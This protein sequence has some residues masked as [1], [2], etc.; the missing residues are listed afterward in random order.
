[1]LASKLHVTHNYL[2]LRL[3]ERCAQCDAPGTVRL[4]Q[5]IK[6]DAVFLSWCCSRCEAEWAI[7]EG[8]PHFVE[9]RAGV[10]DRRRLTRTD[11]RK[12]RA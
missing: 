12:P 5:V 10:S 1:M 6:G 8:E 9:R 3:P 11:R 4:Q 2:S 7:A